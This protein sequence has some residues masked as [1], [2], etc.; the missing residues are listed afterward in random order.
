MPQV[1]TDGKF[2]AYKKVAL[3]TDQTGRFR[4]SII[5]FSDIYDWSESALQET[6]HRECTANRQ[7]PCKLMGPMTREEYDAL[8]TRRIGYC[9]TSDADA[10]MTIEPWP[11]Y[12]R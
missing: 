11:E 6:I 9:D 7:F 8:E 5:R 3:M 12:R 10:E 1:N 4:A 2:W